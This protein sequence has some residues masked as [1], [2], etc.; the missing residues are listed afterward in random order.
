MHLVRESRERNEM[1]NVKILSSMY[2]DARQKFGGS[3]FILI[4]IVNFPFM[5]VYEMVSRVFRIAKYESM[6]V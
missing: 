4:S 2:K 1:A 5:V 6:K 3:R